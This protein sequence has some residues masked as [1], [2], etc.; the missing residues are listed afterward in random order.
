MMYNN[1]NVLIYCSVFL[2]LKNRFYPFGFFFSGC[3]SRHEVSGR[4]NHVPYLVV[5]VKEI[6]RLWVELNQHFL[7]MY[8]ETIEGIIGVT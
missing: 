6:K 8:I 7:P 3:V 2:S 4:P 1:L 5:A